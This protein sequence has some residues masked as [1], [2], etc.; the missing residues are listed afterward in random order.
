MVVVK[1]TE[2]TKPVY[3]RRRGFLL[4]VIL[5]LSLLLVAFEWTTAPQDAE[6]NEQLLDQLAQEMEMT[7][8]DTHDMMSVAE[9][10]PSKAV[11]QNVKAEDHAEQ[12]PQK[13]AS[14]TSPLEIGNGE[15]LNKEAT[16]TEA[17]PET[18]T[19]ALPQDDGNVYKLQTV[20]KLPVFPGGWSALMKWLTKNL[21]YPAIAQRQKIQGKVVV[22][23]IINK[24]GTVS[25]V[26]LEKSIDV[27][28]D[29]E[30]LRVV[31]MMPKWEPAIM[32]DKPCR[33]MFVIPVTFSL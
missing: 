23:F 28:L 32:H 7:S 22:C 31:R 12:E 16:V 24:D 33:C 25:N 21:H 27:N 29:R 4:G 15:G 26:K 18:Q 13:I 30:A 3:E 6:D 10:A 20:E 8:P 9:A 17:T 2:S 14:V 1:K 5:A 19:Q 11:T